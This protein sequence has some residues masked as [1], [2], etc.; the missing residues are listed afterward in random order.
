VRNM[1]FSSGAECAHHEHHQ[2]CLSVDVDAVYCPILSSLDNL[3]S[4]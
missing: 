2:V 4:Y 3:N 1:F